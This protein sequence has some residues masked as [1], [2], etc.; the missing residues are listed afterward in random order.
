ME[1]SESTKKDMYNILY[2]LVDAMKSR[3]SIFRNL[4]INDDQ[5]VIKCIATTVNGSLV[6]KIQVLL[7]N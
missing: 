1:P 2:D 4:K 5:S 7:D 3:P 6:V